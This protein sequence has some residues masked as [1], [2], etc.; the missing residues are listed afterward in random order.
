VLAELQPEF[1]DLTISKI[2]FLEAEGLLTPERTASGYRMYAVADVERLRYVLSAQRDRF[3]PLKVIRE[4]LDALERGLTPGADVTPTRCAP[5]ATDPDV[6]CAA[7][8]GHRPRCASPRPSSRAA[9]R[10][11]EEFQAR[12][13]LPTVCCGPDEAGHYDD[14]ALAVARAAAALAAYGI[15]AR[16]LRPFRTAAEREVGLGAADRSGPNAGGG[17]TTGADSVAAEVLH[18]C[19]ALHAALVRAE[20]RSLSRIACSARDPG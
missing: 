12:W 7:T 6:P 11:D 3:W 17:A 5:A 2:R 13:R 10:L 15:E 9:S 14:A 8:L 1:P 16:H 19:L 20:L 18:H 4:A